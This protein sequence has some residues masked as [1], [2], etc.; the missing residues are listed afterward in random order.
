MRGD[1][2]MALVSWKGLHPDTR[3]SL[4]ITKKEYIPEFL[5]ELEY[6]RKHRK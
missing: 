6:I 3:K 4:K 1:K 5:E 2:K